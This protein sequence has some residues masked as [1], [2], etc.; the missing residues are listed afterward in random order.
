[1]GYCHCGLKE[2]WKENRLCQTHRNHLKSGF[3]YKT[4]NSFFNIDLYPIVSCKIF[5]QFTISEYGYKNDEL[6]AIL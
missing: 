6:D 1:M 5:L 2:S 3:K 4:F